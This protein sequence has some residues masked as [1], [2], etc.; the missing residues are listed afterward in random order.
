MAPY[1]AY[2]CKSMLK[3]AI[4]S[5][6]PVCFLE[7][8]LMYTKNFEVKEDFWDE[9]LVAPI[10]VARKMR[11]GTDVTVIGFS[12]MVGEILKAAEILSKEGIEIEVLNLRTI[13]PLD[14]KGILDSV[15]KTNRLVCVE[16]GYPFSGVG[17]EICGMMM[18]SKGFD[19][20]DAPVERV[21]G[22]D[23]MVPYSPNLEEACL[24]QVHSIVKAVKTTLKGRKF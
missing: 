17:A 2:D 7:N 4:R 21:T 22:W 8:E 13:K 11:E 23:I 10:G 3:A 20:L 14:R 19:Y 1:D 15:K 12:K 5:N 9:E 18:E 16:D 24:P 6:D